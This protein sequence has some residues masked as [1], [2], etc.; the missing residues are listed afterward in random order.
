MNR[1]A[2]WRQLLHASP[3]SKS[4][5]TAAADICCLAWNWASL[6]LPLCT[7]HDIRSVPSRRHVANRSAVC[8]SIMI[9]AV[10][11]V[12]AEGIGIFSERQ[13]PQGTLLIVEPLSVGAKT[14]LARVIYSAPAANGWQH[15][16]SLSNPLD[17]EDLNLWVSD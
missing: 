2:D 16:C 10:R 13:F 5:C 3:L 11:D 7:V 8:L 14:L 1:H 17:G 6:A 12:S 4:L 9:A 15:G